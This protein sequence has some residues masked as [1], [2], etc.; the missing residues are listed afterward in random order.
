MLI[1]ANPVLIMLMVGSL[2]FFLVHVFYQGEFNLKLNFIFAMFVMAIVLIA[3]ISIENGT[4]YAALFALP[5]GAV[6]LIAFQRFV[7][8]PGPLA[9]FSILL[10]AAL[11]ILIWWAA[12]RITWDCTVMDESQEAQGHGLL[13]T[14][15]LDSRHVDGELARPASEDPELD[16]SATTSDE[17]PAEPQGWWARFV[18]RQRRPHAHGVWVIYFAI[19]ALPIFGFGQ[20]WLETVG[21]RRFA[22][23]LFCLYMAS[24]LGLLTTTSLLGLRRYLRQRRLDMPIDMTWT[25]IASGAVLIV[26]VLLACLL[27]PRPAAEYSV[28]DIPW[29]K[30]SSPVSVHTNPGGTLQGKQDSQGGSGNQPAPTN[31]SANGSSPDRDSQNDAP[32]KATPQDPSNSGKQTSSSEN[33]STNGAQQKSTSQNS[34][35]GAQRKSSSQ[36][37][38]GGGQQKSSSQDSS[39]GGQQT[40]SS[41]NATSGAQPKK[42]SSQDSTGGAQQTSSPDASSSGK[43]NSSD[44]QNPN[45]SS[46]QSGET[47]PP[48]STNRSNA[49]ANSEN[50]NQRPD[51]QNPQ[52][53]DDRQATDDARKDG[54]SNRNGSS[55][56]ESSSNNAAR[57]NDDARQQDSQ[58]STGASSNE[59]A[60]QSAAASNQQSNSSRPSNA[61]AASGRNSSSGTARS[62]SEGQNNKASSTSDSKSSSRQSSP[63]QT[64]PPGNVLRNLFQSLPR[65]FSWLYYLGFALLAIWLMWKY[66][67][68]VARFWNQL[69]E[70]LRKLWA[71]LFGG[72]TA[73][74]AAQEADATVA[75]GP[76]YRPFSSYMNPF[77]S[78][79]APRHTAAELVQYTFLALEAWA[80]EQG[81][82]RSAQQTPLE[83]AQMLGQ[84]F[85]ELGI[86]ARQVCDMYCRLAYGDRRLPGQSLAILQT[87]WE[88]LTAPRRPLAPGGV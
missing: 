33:S 85:P 79:M 15:G 26:A 68:Q 28:A 78:G 57:K 55:S 17:T 81:A 5:L 46:D 48:S 77:T 73:Q 16:L 82:T 47:N 70:D 23:L 37:S 66:R 12:H 34:T 75:R 4:E 44:S 9:P 14:A 52:S 39:T 87:F 59:M 58:Q 10:N 71:R 2:T 86:G 43:T 72:R 40:S 53:S 50:N 88:E 56:E 41:Q 64:S 35:N 62:P 84:S 22:L 8:F 38:T 54:S 42:S 51:E 1:A 67:Q 76:Q 19:A 6:T 32:Q 13:Q 74:A 24:G 31:T 49:R 63:P 7:E 80:R 25:W 65:M 30:T 60:R 45:G 20:G 18:A 27:V 29:Q 36:G 83:F 69:L 61:T 11:L 21:Q 3:R